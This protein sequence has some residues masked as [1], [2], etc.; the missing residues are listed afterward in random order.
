MKFSVENKINKKTVSQPEILLFPVWLAPSKAEGLNDGQKKTLPD[1]FPLLDSSDQKLIKNY[2]DSRN[3][4]DGD[5]KLLRLNKK[6]GYIFIS[7]Q[8]DF[9]QKEFILLVR[10]LVRLA[11]SEGLKS[12]GI[13]LDDFEIMDIFAEKLAELAAEN[14]LMAHFDFSENFKTP[15]SGGWKK[16]EEAIL[17][18]YHDSKALS[19]SV[20]RGRMVGEMTNECRML[21]NY[22]PGEMTPEGLVEAAKAI[23]KDNKKIQFTVFDEKKLKSEGMNA[24]LAVGKGSQNPPRLIILEYQGGRPKDPLIALVGKGVTFDSGGLDLKPSSAMQDMHL[25]MSGGAAVMNAIGLMAKLKVP[26]SVIGL[27]PAV[28][29]M[30][31]GFSYR[32]GDIIKAYGGKTIEVTNTDAEGRVILAD[33]IEYAKTKKPKLILTIAT[34]TGAAVTALGERMSA[35]FVKDNQLLRDAL[36]KI[37]EKTGDAVWPLPLT[38]ANEKDVEGKFADVTNTHKNHSRYGGASTGAAFLSHFAKPVPFVHV[39]MAPRMLTI[40][41]EEKLAKGASGFGVRLLLG[42][43]EKWQEVQK[44]LK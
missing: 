38:D 32:Q 2:L 27:I 19:E 40:P 20:E 24:I 16:V 21:S 43:A 42:L 37:G 5:S 35:L 29:N 15:P 1:F 4:K 39:D 31:S 33:A 36:E 10:Q 22:P 41:E 8:K 30:P 11:K 17:Y 7:T 44:L 6:P 18:S 25:D 26:I 13:Y 28:E 12:L 3:W 34:L 9:N 23:V 14:A